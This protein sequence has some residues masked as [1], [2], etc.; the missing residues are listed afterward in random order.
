MS[1]L[2]HN[3]AVYFL[4]RHKDVIRKTEIVNDLFVYLIY[5]FL[6][7]F[8]EKVGTEALS[9]L[10]ARFVTLQSSLSKG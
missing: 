4:G 3:T 5:L 6:F 8:K 9:K 2:Y 10:R 1:A 7:F